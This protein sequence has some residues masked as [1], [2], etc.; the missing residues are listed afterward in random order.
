M[1]KQ[2]QIIT[3]VRHEPLSPLKFSEPVK[4]G[5]AELDAID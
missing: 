5:S 1:S 4:F 3:D 2:K